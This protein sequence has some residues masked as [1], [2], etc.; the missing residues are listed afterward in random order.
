MLRATNEPEMIQSGEL[1]VSA[2]THTWVTAYLHSSPSIQQLIT[3]IRNG[4]AVAVGD[5]LYFE[6]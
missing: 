5:G 1:Q 3:D 4:V 2:P 6:I